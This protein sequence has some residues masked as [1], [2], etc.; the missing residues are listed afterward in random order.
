[1]GPLSCPF[2]VEC[3]FH[4]VAKKTLSNSRLEMDFCEM[5][6]DDC[7]IAQRI[8]SSTRVPSG[9]LPDGKYRV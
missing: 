6:Y 1:V 4:N 8:L 3:E 7:E 9:M 2:Q 5:R